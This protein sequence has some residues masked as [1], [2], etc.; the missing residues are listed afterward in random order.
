[1]KQ[2]TENKMIKIYDPNDIKRW[3]DIYHQVLSLSSGYTDE[4][5]GLLKLLNS[6]K[7]IPQELRDKH[8][9]ER[10][11]DLERSIAFQNKRD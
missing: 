7:E 2:R 6:A 8:L 11:E 9:N 5:R 1:M 3:F 10:I 4:I